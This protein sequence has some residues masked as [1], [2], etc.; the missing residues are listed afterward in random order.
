MEFESCSNYLA[1]EYKFLAFTKIIFFCHRTTY[2]LVKIFTDLGVFVRIDSHWKGRFND[3][4]DWMDQL[5][6]LCVLG[7]LADELLL[8]SVLM[9]DVWLSFRSPIKMFDFFNFWYLQ[10]SQVPDLALKSLANPKFTL[11]TMCQTY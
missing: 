7:M 2:S 11:F 10:I 6:F 4:V 5:T 8:Q 1:L 9:L 3:P